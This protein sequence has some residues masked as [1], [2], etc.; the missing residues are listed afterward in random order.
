MFV[1]PIPIPPVPPA[2]VEVWPSDPPLNMNI[3]FCGYT[4]DGVPVKCECSEEERQE[5]GTTLD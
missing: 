3:E 2:I 1:C 4:S 5:N